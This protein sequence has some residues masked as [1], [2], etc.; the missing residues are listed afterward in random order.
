MKQLGRQ[1]GLNA[2]Q[3]DQCVDT[4]KYQ[5][6]IQ[7]HL[8]LAED[9]KIMQTPTFHDRRATDCRRAQL[10]RR[11]RR[12]STAR[13]PKRRQRAGSATRR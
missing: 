12:F 9:R 8:K 6:K 4:K 11:S 10:R 5:A 7:A 2:S 13:W 3:F 1:L